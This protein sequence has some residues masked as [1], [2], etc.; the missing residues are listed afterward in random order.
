MSLYYDE[1]RMNLFY[2]EDN[3]YVTGGVE[4]G[5]K[6][7][8]E[9]QKARVALRLRTKIFLLLLFFLCGGTRKAIGAT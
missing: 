5:E 6:V 4:V 7:K 3:V 1:C 2:H 8:K 9:H